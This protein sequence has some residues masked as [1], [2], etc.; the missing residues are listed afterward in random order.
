VTI[1]KGQRL[2]ACAGINGEL[3]LRDPRTLRVE[4]RIEAHTGGICDIDIKGDLLVSCGWSTRYEVDFFF[5]F[6]I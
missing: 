1:R 3:S 2:V 5:F 4:H 6:S